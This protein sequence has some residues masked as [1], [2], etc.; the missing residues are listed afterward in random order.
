MRGYARSWWIAGGWAIDLFLGRTTRPHQDVD[1]AVLR[2]DQ[3]T[4]RE[5]LRGW[6]FTKMVNGIAI[7]WPEHE[8]LE[9]PIH[10]IHADSG[11]DRL[12]FLFNEA[13]GDVWRFRRNLEVSAPLARITRRTL[14]DVPYLA[15]EI[16]LLYKAKSPRQKDHDDFAHALPKLDPDAR[17]WLA[18]ALRICHPEHEWLDRLMPSQPHAR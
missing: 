15:P 17:S 16:V 4:L 1:V 14:D 8:R 11:G 18:S 13:A 5:H 9:L 6:R 2:R 3:S 7:E 10:E 12:E